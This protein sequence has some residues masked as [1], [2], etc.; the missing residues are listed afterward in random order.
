[1]HR[2][3]S[4]TCRTSSAGSRRWRA[5]WSCWEDRRHYD[6]VA[7]TALR[8]FSQKTSNCWQESTPIPHCVRGFSPPFGIQ[9]VVAPS[10]VLYRETRTGSTPKAHWTH[11]KLLPYDIHMPSR[12]P[13][14][15][16]PRA[17]DVNHLIASLPPEEY[18]RLLPHLQRATLSLGEIIHESGA[19][20]NHVYFPTSP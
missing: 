12:M 18:R 14:S 13:R 6:A 3:R 5:I 1:M 11:M 7:A 19:H 10:D 9:S 20:P 8:C 17:P 16:G 15:A 4:C 2:M